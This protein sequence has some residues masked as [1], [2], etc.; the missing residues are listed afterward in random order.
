MAPRWVRREAWL[1]TDTQRTMTT[2]HGTALLGHTELLFYR[3]SLRPVL[4]RKDRFCSISYNFSICTVTAGLLNSS[5][6][7]P[8]LTV[9]LSL[10][11][12]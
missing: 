2:C 5:S 11:T 4:I 3:S 6:V 10:K 1:L 8:R 9:T 12:T 7:S